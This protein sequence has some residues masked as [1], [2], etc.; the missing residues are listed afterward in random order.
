MRSTSIRQTVKK[1]RIEEG[2]I[3]EVIDP[4]KIY[5]HIET[6]TTDVNFDIYQHMKYNLKN[7]GSICEI[8]D[9]TLNMYCL[10]CKR[11]ICEVCMESTHSNHSYLKKTD[12]NPEI[13]FIRGIFHSLECNISKTEELVQTDKLIKAYKARAEEEFNEISM[14]LN[15]L[16]SKRMREIENMFGG[17]TG[18]SKNLI[19]NVDKTKK[20]LINYI[21]TWTDFIDSKNNDDDNF[22]FLHLYD[23]FNECIQKNKEYNAVIEKI[24]THYLQFQKSSEAKYSNILKE[25]EICLAQQKRNDINNSNLLILEAEDGNF[26]KK[27][28]FKQKLGVQFE[29]LN[30]DLFSDIRNKVGKFE[31][32]YEQFKVFVFESFK[33]GGSLAEIDRIVKA[34]E[35]KSS[36]KIQYNGAAGLKLS[37]SSKSRT[38]SAHSK[39]SRESSPSES[40]TKANAFTYANDKKENKLNSVDESEEK[41][42]IFGSPNKGG[43]SSE[44]DTN[45]NLKLLVPE[46]ED[47]IV[48]I[49]N[50]LEKSRASRGISS[51]EK[52]FRPKPNLLHKREEFKYDKRRVTERSERTE[53]S[54]V[55]HSVSAKQHNALS[56]GN[57]KKEEHGKLNHKL[58]ENIKE[59]EMQNELIKRKEDISIKIPLI[60]KYYAYSTLEFVQKNFNLS[61]KG[62]SSGLLF[63]NQNSQGNGSG[64]I[65][66][67]VIEGTNEVMIYSRNKRKIKRKKV[68]IEKLRFGTSI[69]P[70]GCRSITYNGKVY[71]SGGKDLKGDKSLF[72]CYNIK[73][74]KLSKLSDSKFPHSYHAIVFHENLRSILLIG[75]EQSSKCE[76]YDIYMNIWSQLPDLLYPRAKVNLYIDKLGA[77]VYT[78]FGI[79]GNLCKC[80][81]SDVIEV[82][83]LVDTSKGWAKIEYKNRS[84]VDLRKSDLKVFDLTGDKILLYGAI[85]NRDYHHCHVV[86][87]LKSFDMYRINEVDL[88]SI[89]VKLAMP[90]E[91]LIKSEK[92]DK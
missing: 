11:S 34:F 18:D 67:K 90:V 81:F 32:H 69:F 7:S 3:L 14:K 30:E 64:E 86:F 4:L 41:Q 40:K 6:L 24:K 16:K 44:E 80:E 25:I 47:I 20:C 65:M 36:K 82:L 21:Q 70:L 39:K 23:V 22:I 42:K 60:R 46:K 89:K 59:L 56:P 92:E 54:L 77:Y 75:G 83:D 33:K 49:K 91:L 1:T 17:N 55:N 13:M 19:K 88:E 50:N 52:M 62:F 51:L 2:P 68:N 9:S 28:E 12:I 73:E 61:S 63:D 57:T 71:I 76:L 85:E 78:I 48:N 58:L 43:S 37:Y 15:E 29:K 8:H 38:R 87:D 74:D 35:E 5:P 10:N 84:S 26:P 31:Q 72:W 53:T 79:T 27:E 66:V 45:R